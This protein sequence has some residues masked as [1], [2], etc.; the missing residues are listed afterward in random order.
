MNTKNIRWKR[1]WI[2]AKATKRGV[3]TK[4]QRK[5]EKRKTRTKVKEF[6]ED[7]LR[8]GKNESKKWRKERQMD[9]D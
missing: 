9:Y 4:S 8:D 2:L 6:E 5:R 7:I 1:K 3:H